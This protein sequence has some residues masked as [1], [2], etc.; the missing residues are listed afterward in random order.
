MTLKKNLR[1]HR[2]D[3]LAFC[4]NRL[5]GL[6]LWQGLGFHK[7]SKRVHGGNGKRILPAPPHLRRGQAVDDTPQALEERLLLEQG[8]ESAGNE[9]ERYVPVLLPTVLVDYLVR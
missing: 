4:I 3:G 1:G 8:S 7:S 5:E 2:K 6:P 9:H